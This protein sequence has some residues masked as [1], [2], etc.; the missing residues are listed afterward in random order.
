VTY[1]IVQLIGVEPPMGSIFVGVFAS[2]GLVDLVIELSKNMF[3]KFEIILPALLGIA[4]LSYILYCCVLASGL[5]KIEIEEMPEVSDRKEYEKNI[6]E[7]SD[8]IAFLFLD[9]KKLN[10]YYAIN[11]NQGRLIFYASILALFCGVF[12]LAYGLYRVLAMEISITD[13]STIFSAL[14]GAVV[15]F[16]AGLFLKLYRDT[17]ARS[18]EYFSQLL[19]IQRILISIRLMETA[20]TAKEEKQFRQTIIEK[21]LTDFNDKT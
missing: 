15:N 14:S 2:V 20:K 12:M 16:M 11:Q 10:E 3:H 17:Q 5:F 1:A 9:N 4:A 18:R 6:K 13:K 21:L 19:K 7:S 8:P